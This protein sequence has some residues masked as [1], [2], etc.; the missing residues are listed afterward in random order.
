MRKI[1]ERGL[2]G[3]L[4]IIISMLVHSLLIRL[5]IAHRQK[6]RFS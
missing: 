4:V 5:K 6:L 1:S 2:F 3:V